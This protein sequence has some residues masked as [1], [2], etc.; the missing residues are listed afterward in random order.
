MAISIVAIFVSG[1]ALIF[2][3]DMGHFAKRLLMVV[4]AAALMIGGGAILTK[5]AGTAG[6][7]M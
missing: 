2:G 4:I 5:L 6:A 1:I 7:F 3:E